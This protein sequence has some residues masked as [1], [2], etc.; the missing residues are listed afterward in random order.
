MRGFRHLGLALLLLAASGSAFLTI[1]AWLASVPE[2]PESG[3]SDDAVLV[4]KVFGAIT[5][6]SLIAAMSVMKINGGGQ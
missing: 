1:V 3:R 4:M 2:A 6:V 5:L